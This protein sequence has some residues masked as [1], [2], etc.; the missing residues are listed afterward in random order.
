MLLDFLRKSKSDSYLRSTHVSADPAWVYSHTENPISLHVH[1]HT[2][3][4][5]VQGALR[6]QANQFTMQNCHRCNTQP[7]MRAWAPSR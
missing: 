3:R 1:S 4:H 6:R 5:H 7:S 2:A